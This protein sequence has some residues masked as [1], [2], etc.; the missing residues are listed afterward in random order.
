ML[1]RL[2]LLHQQYR[3]RQELKRVDTQL[4]RLSELPPAEVP[5]LVPG[6]R[7]GIV[8]RVPVPGQSDVFMCLPNYAGQ[9]NFVVHVN[10]LAFYRAW[11][12]LPVT[13]YQSCPLKP[14]MPKDRKFKHAASCFG[15]GIDSPVPIA[16]VGP[17]VDQ[18][19][20]KVSFTD[21]I[22]RSLWLLAHDVPTFPVLCSDLDSASL[23]AD[24]AGVAGPV[25]VPT[26]EREL[27]RI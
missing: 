9:S 1:Q 2:K 19:I 14:D 26:L 12:A 27:E 21:G 23:L 6:H 5:Q 16:D 13:H 7:R 10:G 25:R 4:A 11:L 17:W 20:F 3:V 24:K 22:T 8:W 18:G 15:A